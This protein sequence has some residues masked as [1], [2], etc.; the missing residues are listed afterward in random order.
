[1]T[2]RIESAQSI[3]DGV[4]KPAPPETV[5]FEALFENEFDYVYASLRRMG[6][7]DADLP[8]LTH[9]VFIA[10]HRH[11]P[12]FDVSRPARPWLFGIAFRVALGFKRR[13]RQHYEVLADPETHV[14]ADPS[15]HAQALLEQR[16]AYQVL[17][18]AIA[19]LDMD[20]RAVFV[21]HDIDGVPVPE[22]AATLEIP[23]NTAYSRLRLAREAVT[24]HVKRVQLQRGGR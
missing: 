23:V 19:Q 15:P 13:A 18:D 9:D 16:E 20:R 14:A 4:P 21:L 17:Y 7:R 5:T 11:L 12:E 24:A 3:R 1:M 10:V 6:I 2:D 22:V 8:D